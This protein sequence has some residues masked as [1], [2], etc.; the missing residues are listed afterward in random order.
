MGRRNP[1][2][3]RLVCLRIGLV[4]GG[5]VV[6]SAVL[7]ASSQPILVAIL[8]VVSVGNALAFV[9]GDRRML[10]LSGRPLKPPWTGTNTHSAQ[11]LA[12]LPMTEAL[13]IAL[14]AVTVVGERRPALVSDREAV[15]WIGNY[16]TNIPSRQAYQIDV[17]VSEGATGGKVFICSARPQRVMSIGGINQSKKLVDRLVQEVKRLTS[18]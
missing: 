8:G 18:T 3:L 2:Y 1:E 16:W 7:L 17:F 13:Q 6:V 14:H 10:L 9:Y 15:S 12:N 4:V 11:I 5:Y